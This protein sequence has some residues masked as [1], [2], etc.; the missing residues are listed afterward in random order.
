MT[1][2]PT[3]VLTPEAEAALAD[4][5]IEG[6]SAAPTQA[7]KNVQCERL[8]ERVR[9]LASKIESCLKDETTSIEMKFYY[10]G[11]NLT[12]LSYLLDDR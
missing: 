3:R 11:V 2:E 12:A 9:V 7:A 8:R 1:D 6:D 5:P 4:G 10:I